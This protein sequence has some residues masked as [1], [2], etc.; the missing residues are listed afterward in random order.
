[1]QEVFA[2]KFL[3]EQFQEQELLVNI[4]EHISNSTDL[5]Q[6]FLYII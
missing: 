4:T 1:M 6:T 5:Y 3:I 2:P